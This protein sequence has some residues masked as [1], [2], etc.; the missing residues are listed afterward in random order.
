MLSFSAGDGTGNVDYDPKNH[1]HMVET[2]QRKIDLIAN[3]IP[4]QTVFGPESGELLV[5]SWGGTYGAVRT[6]V[7]RSIK[8]G[9]SV[10]HCH[11]RYISPFPRNLQEVFGNYKKI[12]I[13]ELNMG[14]L[15]LIIRG[16]YLVDAQGFNKIQG[17]PFLVSELTSKIDEMLS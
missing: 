2:R 3:D 6:A 5:V 16:K 15:R 8:A 12:L 11:I 13:P 4:E 9:K 14:Q 7:D 17:K 10:A 1:Q